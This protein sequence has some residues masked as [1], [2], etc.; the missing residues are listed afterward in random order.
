MGIKI[1]SSKTGTVDRDFKFL[2]VH[3]DLKEATL[4]Y[5]GSKISI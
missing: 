1:E 2:G 4:E 3:F 5:S